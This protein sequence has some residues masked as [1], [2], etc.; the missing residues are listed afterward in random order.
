[1]VEDDNTYLANGE[2]GSAGAVIERLIEVA[3]DHRN[4]ATV[5]YDTVECS[6]SDVI[7]CVPC[8]RS[9]ALDLSSLWSKILPS[10]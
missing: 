6:R 7:S 1:M 9:V 5:F 3:V 10:S 2:V 8:L 4:T